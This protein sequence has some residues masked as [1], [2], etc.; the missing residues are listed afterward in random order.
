MGESADS[1]R[2]REPDAAG[3]DPRAVGRRIFRDTCLASAV[4]VLVSA[5]VAPWRVTTGLLL[6]GALAVFNL[7]WL[8]TS[9]AAVF[10]STPAGARPRMRAARYVLRYVVVAVLIFAA[11][12]LGLVSLVATLAG[13]CATVAALLA[14]GVRQFYFAITRREEI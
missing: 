4:A 11:V 3:E 7:H 10:G 9:V 13:M 14:E 8:S 2:A 6:G 12:T 5:F 1:T